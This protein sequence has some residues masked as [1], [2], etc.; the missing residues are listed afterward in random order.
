MDIIELL[1]KYDI[2]FYKSNNSSWPYSSRGGMCAWFLNDFQDEDFIN[3][4]LDYI[5]EL[6]AGGTQDYDK[7]LISSDAYFARIKDSM[8]KISA[9]YRSGNG[10]IQIIPLSDFK[11]ILEEWLKFIR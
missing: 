5:T 1:R 3:E 9:G 2:T 7:D 6:L 11:L 8:V 10:A 4:A